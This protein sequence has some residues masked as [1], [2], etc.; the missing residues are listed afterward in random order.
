[1]ERS[2]PLL[3]LLICAVVGGGA[4]LFR[5]QATQAD[6]PPPAAEVVRRAWLE[7]QE[8]PLRGRQEIMFP[9]EGDKPTTVAA[10]VLHSADG[11]IRIEYQSAPL[12]GVKVWENADR[13]YRYNPKLERLSVAMRPGTPEERAARELKLLQQ[14]YIAS[15][16]DEDKV[17]GEETWVI[18]LRPAAGGKLWK[19]LWVDKDTAVILRSED[20]RDQSVLRHTTFVS[21]TYLAPGATLAAAEFTP[22]T[23]LVERYGRA[24]PGDTSS[25]FEDLGVLSKLVG[26]E[27]RPPRRLP[28]GYTFEGGYQTPCFC[29][30]DHQAVRLRYTD[31]LNTISVFEAGHPECTVT[32]RDPKGRPFT[33]ELKEGKRYYRAVGDLPSDELA[34]ILKSAATASNP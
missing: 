27:V 7:G 18:A 23:E 22:P 26:F 2:A 3:I 20:L 9:N 31:G 34:A 25:R 30:K 10:T 16:E 33:A 29:G 32:L 13:V 28:Q 6:T 1:M 12:E 14:N 24:I 17:A 11:N 4:W 15:H 21:V 8:V 19:R 5:N